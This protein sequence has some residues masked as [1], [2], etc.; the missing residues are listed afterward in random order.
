MQPQTRI[1]SI[2]VKEITRFERGPLSDLD[3]WEFVDG[4]VHAIQCHPNPTLGDD[5][6]VAWYKAI[7]P[8]GSEADGLIELVRAYLEKPTVIDTEAVG[9]IEP[10]PHSVARLYVESR[11]TANSRQTAF[12]ALLRVARLVKGQEPTVEKREYREASRRAWVYSL[13]FET[14]TPEALLRIRS[15]LNEKY[16]AATVN[17]TLSVLRGVMKVAWLSGLISQEHYSRVVS[18]ED[19]KS[20]TLPIGRDVEGAELAKLYAVLAELPSPQRE[21]ERA[22]F[23]VLQQGLRASEVIA[24]IIDSLTDGNSLVVQGKG[25]QQREVFLHPATATALQA[26]LDMRGREPGPLFVRIR[27]GGHITDDGLSRQGLYKIVREYTN[28]AGLKTTTP[29]DFRR[30]FVGQL[31]SAGHD[32]STVAK[33]AGHKQVT[34]TQRY[35]RRPL[36]AQR[37]AVTDLTIPL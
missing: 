6:T 5:E 20:K 31:L 30:T 35:D 11:N 8:D 17:N 3:I 28:Q 33:Q 15:L 34:T 26:W 22:L 13:P 18:I 23:A 36:D 16:A 14:L 9:A 29:H 27:R 12:N 32:I 24:L 2:A 4:A 7:D 10:A 37:R 25:N 1:A 19:V 21:R